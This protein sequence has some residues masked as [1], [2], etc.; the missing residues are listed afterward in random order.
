MVASSFDIAVVGTGIPGLASA[1]GFAQQGLSVAL[2]GPRPKPYAVTRAQPFDPRVYAVAPASVALLESLGVW[3]SVDQERVCAV[4]H[5]RVFGDEGT[6]L[7]FDAYTATVERLATIV[8]ESELLRVLDAACG[9]QPAIKRIQSTFASLTAQP[10]T[11]AVDLEDGGSLTARLLVGADGASSAVRAAA[12]INATVKSYDQTAVVAN[13][14]CARPH[15]N[16]AWQWFTDQGVVALLPLPGEHVSLVWSAPQELAVELAALSADQLAGRVTERCASAAGD[17][18]GV[19]QLTPIGK[20]HTFPL[21]RV[22]VSRLIAS[23]VGLVGDAAHVVHPL[24]GQGLNLGLQDV[25]LLLE[26]VR[27][28]EAFRDVG[29]ATV[30]RR[31]ERGRAEALGLMRFTTDSLAQLFAFDD[32]LV[33]RLRNAGMAA[34]NRLSPLKNALIRRALG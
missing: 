14:G 11:V 29:D 28:R 17:T 18:T 16:T 34:V 23:R 2:V 7:T 20:A 33:R 13:F 12:G 25:A 6:Q 30:L 26:V 24:A 21:R 4:E 1:L 5:M 9:F 10:D 15:L 31:Y 22:V 8:E 3:A 32:P 27:A 19:G